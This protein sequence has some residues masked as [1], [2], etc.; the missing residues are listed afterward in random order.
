MSLSFNKRLLKSTLLPK[1]LTCTKVTHICW[2]LHYCTATGLESF[3]SRSVFIT[4]EGV[5]KVGLEPLFSLWKAFTS[6]YDFCPPLSHPPS[7]NT[8]KGA[9]VPELQ[10][11]PNWITRQPSFLLA[12]QS[13]DCLC[14][15]RLLLNLLLLCVGGTARR[16]F[17][18]QNFPARFLTYYDAALALDGRSDCSS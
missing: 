13:P 16:W 3:V 10:Y 9:T 14:A 8:L 7:S 15:W 18:H 11:V 17:P 2:A 12:S 1:D 5:L 6:L 4:S